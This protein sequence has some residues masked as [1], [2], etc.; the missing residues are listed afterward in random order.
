MRILVA[1]DHPLVREG[2]RTVVQAQWPDA[3]VGEAGTGQEALELACSATWNVLLLDLSIPPDGGLETLALVKR[4][5]PALPVLIFTLHSEAK[6]GV[7]AIKQGAAGYLMKDTVPEKLNQAIQRV[8]SGG[9][10]VSEG[11]AELLVFRRD[12]RQGGS[13]SDQLTR[14]EFQVMMM[15]G[16]GMS[17]KK[18][19]EEMGL[20][21]R[22]IQWYRACVLQKLHL[23]STAALVHYVVSRGLVMGEDA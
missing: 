11:L 17:V 1:D 12:D 2:V 3:T 5:V 19:A 13:P 4:D 23:R 16:Q 6:Y 14:R 20:N 15:L 18:I 10:Y 21:H 9:R 8:T 7:K 22:T